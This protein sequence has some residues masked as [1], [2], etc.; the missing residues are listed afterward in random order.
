MPAPALS[1]N[2]DLMHCSKRHRYSISSS[3]R[4]S[5]VAGTSTPSGR[6]VVTLR[7]G[8]QHEDRQ[9]AAALPRRHRG[10]SERPL[11]EPPA[12]GARPPYGTLM[13]Q[14]WAPSTAS[15]A[16]DTVGLRPLGMSA[17]LKNAP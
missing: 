8:H 11:L 2:R 14:E 9:G 4:M 6:G 7:I 17:L 15:R 16:P 3:A 1:A 12:W 5:R 13:P 10:L